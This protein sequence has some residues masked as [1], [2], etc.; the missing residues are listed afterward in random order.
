LLLACAAA[1]CAFS[2]K[3]EDGVIACSPERNCPPG[4]GCGGDQ[5]CYRSQAVRRSPT[6]DAGACV[7]R[8]CFRGWCGAVDD[9]CGGQLDC[10]PCNPPSDSDG[11]GGSV[12]SRPPDLAGCQP[13]HACIAGVSC[14]LIDDG[15]GQLVSCGDCSVP[16]TCSS[17]SPNS[18][19]CRPKTCAD[20]NANCGMHPTGCGGMMKCG[21][22]SGGDTCGGGGPY[23]CGPGS[24]SAIVCPPGA[25][26]PIPDGCRGILHCGPCPDGAVCGGAGTPNVC[27]LAS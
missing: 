11:D 25:C 15:C 26:G 27:P 8:H 24:C 20:L 19:V 3:I 12:A 7:R 13:S 22:C 5:L 16:R 21:T 17:T 9:G 6:S 14:G 23:R 10:G 4:F 2:P 1:G 18:C